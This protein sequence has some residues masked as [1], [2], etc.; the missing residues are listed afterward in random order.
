VIRSFR[1]EE[2]Q[3]LFKSGRALEKKTLDA[4]KILDVL[5]V[6]DLASEP[7]DA[8]FIG[9]RYDEWTEGGRQ[10]CGVMISDHWLVSYGWSEGHAIDVDL[11]R[12]D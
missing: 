11:E 12:L 5:D 3:R 8:A 6:V 2:L 1:S 10:R 7:Q 9:F 4:Q